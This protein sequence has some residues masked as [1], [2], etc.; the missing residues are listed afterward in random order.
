MH[1]FGDS[2]SFAHAASQRTD[3][4]GVGWPLVAAEVELGP[5]IGWEHQS[6]ADQVDSS[7]AAGVSLPVPTETLRQGRKREFVD[8]E[9]MAC[10]ERSGKERRLL[11]RMRA[12]ELAEDDCR[13]LWAPRPCCVVPRLCVG[14]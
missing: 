9:K 2:C 3:E 6:R 1:P 4:G 10:M 5:E 8:L 7:A 13:V 12:T 11:E 14:P